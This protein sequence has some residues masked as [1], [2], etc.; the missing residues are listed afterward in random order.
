MSRVP[1]LESAVMQILWS[2]EPD[3]LTPGE[4][5]ERLAPQ[6]PVA[7]TTAM[8]VLVRLWKKGRLVRHRVGRAFAYAPAQSWADYGADRMASILDSVGDRSKTLT[9]FIATLTPSERAQL[10]KLI[11]E[12]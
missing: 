3:A 6:H 10:R 5:R 1:S 7:Y 12:R 8:T 11:E 4:V 2:A 9:R